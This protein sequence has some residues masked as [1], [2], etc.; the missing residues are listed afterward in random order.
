M[1]VVCVIAEQEALVPSEC[2]ACFGRQLQL[3][4]DSNF[5]Q[6]VELGHR[7]QKYR[8]SK[9]WEV[10]RVYQRQKCQ[11]HQAVVVAEL[12]IDALRVANIL[13]AR[14]VEI[15]DVAILEVEERGGGVFVV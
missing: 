10:V 8:I 5:E 3:P 1:C 14:L 15:D 9:L 4:P 11:S 12:P 6:V 7:G 13:V 2:A